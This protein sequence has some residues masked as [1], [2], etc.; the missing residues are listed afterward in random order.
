MGADELAAL[1]HAAMEQGRWAAAREA[2]EAS[3]AEGATAR[4]RFGLATALWWLGENEASVEQCTRAFAAFRRDGDRYGAVDCAL[5]LAITYK[6]NFANGAAAQGWIAR[7]ERLLAA[8]PVGAAHAWLW[9]TRA[10]RMADLD[11]AEALTRAGAR[12]VP[13]P[14]GRRP[15][16]GR[17]LPARP[18]PGRQGRHGRRVRADRRVD[19]GGARRRAVEPR[20]RRLH[21][22]RHAERLRAGRRRRAGR[23]LVPGRR[24]LRGDLRLP[25]PLRRVPHLLRQR[26]GRD[27][28]VER[29]RAGARRRPAHHRAQLSR[30]PPQGG[31][32]PRRPP[33]P[34]GAAGGG[35]AAARRSGWEH[36]GGDRRHAGRRPPARW[37]GGRRNG[38]LACSHSASTAWRA[39]APSW[40]ARSTSSSTPSW[41]PATWRGPRPPSS[42]SGRPSAEGRQA[43]PATATTRS[44]RRPRGRVAAARH[45]IPAAVAALEAAAGRFAELSLP[46]EA[47]RTQLDLGRALAASDP[48]LAIAHAR[49]ALGRV[50]AARRRLRRGRGG[51]VP[52][53]DGGRRPGRAQG[54]RHAHRPG[55]GRAA[56]AGRRLVE[57]R[58]RGAP[59]DEPQ[60]RRPPRQQHPQQAA[61]AQPRPGRRLRRRAR[62][63]R[64]PRRAGDGSPARCSRADAVACSPP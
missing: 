11:A 21:L 57:P 26:A 2:F 54:H 60:D 32:P 44:S 12:A 51:G 5:W 6:A 3:L 19:G 63:D 9:L 38:P 23:P 41:P 31:Q 62:G 49:R 17:R 45:E 42:G 47:A 59:A 14:R 64:P 39:T 50:R 46:F 16:A 25:V 1:G 36:R 30:P 22:L 18:D 10:Y 20:D 29:R 53:G 28:A 15:R 35:G 27:R 8:E 43:K 56:A 58:D 48:D 61:A 13:G 33:H 52:A 37:P 7:A 24:R 4:A 34:P 55:A 40:P